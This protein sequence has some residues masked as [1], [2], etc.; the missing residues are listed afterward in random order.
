VLYEMKSLNRYAY[1]FNNPTSLTDPLGLGPCDGN[2]NSSACNHDTQPRDATGSAIDGSCYMDGIA[3]PCF[4]VQNSLVAGFSA[5][6]PN[7]FC[8]GFA[9]VGNGQIA[10]VQFAAH[11][12]LGGSGYDVLTQ[13]IPDPSLPINQIYA[14]Y[15]LACQHSATPCGSNDPVSVRLQG[16]TYNVLLGHSLDPNSNAL[17][18]RDPV[19]F[20]HDAPSWYDWSPID[21]GHWAA[22]PLG[23]DA[24]Y[25]AFN[26]V[27]LFPL[28]E[29]FDYLP[30]LFVNPKPGVSLGTYTCSTGVGCHP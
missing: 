4:V 23:V 18:I 27:L 6:C 1:V 10:F 7:N 28:H 12:G 21:A 22:T 25:D 20:V 29:I 8:S 30:S 26:G 9:P 19:N 15:Q 2:P 11:A 24:H 14:A 3:T 17:D 13:P 16:T 5:P